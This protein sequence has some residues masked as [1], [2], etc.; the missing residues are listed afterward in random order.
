M[1]KEVTMR[2]IGH[3]ELERIANQ[4]NIS[5][6]DLKIVGL[7]VNHISKDFTVSFEHIEAKEQTQ[8]ESGEK[9]GQEN[10]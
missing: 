4:L 9:G 6:K 2:R 1:K 7:R 8:E 3:Y 10:A 5:V